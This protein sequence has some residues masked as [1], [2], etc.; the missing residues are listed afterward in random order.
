MMIG[1]SEFSRQVLEETRQYTFAQWGG[2]QWLRYYRHHDAFDRVKQAP[3]SGRPRDLFLQGMRS[4]N[5]GKHIIFYA[6]TKAAGGAV[7]VP[8]ILHQR[9]HLPAPVYYEDI[10]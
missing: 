4:L 8:G 2:E 10:E 9:R 7:F 3:P 1:L 6:P 5:Y